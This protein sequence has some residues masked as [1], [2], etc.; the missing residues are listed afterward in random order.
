MRLRTR[1]TIY[2]IS[3]VLIATVLNVSFL[4]FSLYQ[5]LEKE[6][7]KQGKALISGHTVSSYLAITM[8]KPEFIGAFSQAVVDHPDAISFAIYT[9][10]G[11]LVTSIEEED[12]GQ[13]SPYMIDTLAKRESVLFKLGHTEKGN[14][15]YDFF[16]SVRSPPPF[17]SLGGEGELAGFIRIGL[18]TRRLRDEFGKFLIWSIIFTGFLLVIA[19]IVI[20]SLS[21]RIVRP[22]K[23]LTKTAE[24]LAGEE[25]STRIEVD[26]T[27]E[28]GELDRILTWAAERLKEQRKRLELSS[29]VLENRVQERTSELNKKTEELE[30][31]RTA[32]LYM[33]EDLDR[34]Y[35]TLKKSQALM[36][37]AE[38]LSSVGMLTASVAH[39]LNNALTPLFGNLDMLLSEISE[40][41]PFRDDIERI[42]HSA[43][44]CKEIVDNLLDFSKQKEYKFVYAD[45]KD[46]LNKAISLASYQI[47]QNRIRLVKRYAES[48][49]VVRVSPSHIQVVFL[50]LIINACEAMSESGT[51]TI[52]AERKDEMLDISFENTGVGIEKAY[53]QKIFEPFFSTK[54]KGTGLGLSTA[55]DI[56]KAHN[57]VIEVESKGGGEGARFIVKLPEETGGK[58]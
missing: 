31:A 20:S 15:F 54:W 38:R 47:K 18:S 56:V 23:Q 37:Q 1:F 52:R 19:F 43:K 3:L 36:L 17:V 53:L 16:V 42:K 35:E 55:Q 32:T 10:E 5:R 22:I 12:V 58:A 29:K 34:A 39:E 30:D 41:E 25:V 7:I 9:S 4:L 27:D 26:S 2:I 57:G 24:A 21:N 40:D 51:L 48:L 14:P 45:I 8:D 49:P 50:N 28:I 46:I 33:L 11:E 44:R 13:P 6:L